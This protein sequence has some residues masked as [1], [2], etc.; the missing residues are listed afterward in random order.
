MYSKLH[1]LCLAF[2]GCS[3]EVAN[4]V[5]VE[6]DLLSLLPNGVSNRGL[7]ISRPRQNGER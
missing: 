4:K 5:I 6:G 3:K 1:N 2:H 7:R